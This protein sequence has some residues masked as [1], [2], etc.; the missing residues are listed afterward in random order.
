[1]ALPEWEEA[2]L[3][4][5]EEAALP[6]WE[7]AALPAW[8]EVALPAWEE[9]ASAMASAVASAVAGVDRRTKLIELQASGHPAIPMRPAAPAERLV[10]AGLEPGSVGVSANPD[11]TPCHPHSWR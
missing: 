7:E 3:P 6:D 1:M 4:D 5:W 11:A 2:A 9:V 10:A 8:E